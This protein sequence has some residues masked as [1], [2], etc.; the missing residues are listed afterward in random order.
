MEVDFIGFPRFREAHDRAC[1][2]F[3]SGGPAGGTFATG[4]VLAGKG[5]IRNVWN[6]AFRRAI[7]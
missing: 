1:G 2:C 6:C 5:T 4:S 7:G 3:L